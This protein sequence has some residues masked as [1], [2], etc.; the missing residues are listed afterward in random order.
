M[1]EEGNP[2]KSDSFLAKLDKASESIL[3]FAQ[4][5]SLDTV[6]YISL[7]LAILFSLMNMML[8]SLAVGVIMGI[9]FAPEILG[10]GGRVND[11][12]GDK[13]LFRIVLLITF[14]VFLALTIPYFFIGSAA[15][16]GVRAIIHSQKK[17]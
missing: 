2:K 14:A 7:V 5:N 15:A 13:G 9:Y 17:D 1:T 4:N 8:G 16:V 3:D 11:Y 10:F 12:L 6:A